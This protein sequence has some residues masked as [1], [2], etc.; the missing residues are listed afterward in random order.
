M[1]PKNAPCHAV[2]GHPMT[3]NKAAHVPA[4]ANNPPIAPSTVLFGLTAVSLFLPKF[5]P[6]A[7]APTSA[8]TTEST[9]VIVAARP[10]VQIPGPPSQA[11]Q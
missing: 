4:Q 2:P 9:M 11:G 7:Y 3:E 10:R 1:T 8:L 5:L 6:N